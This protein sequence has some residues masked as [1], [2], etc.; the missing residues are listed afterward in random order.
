LFLISQD[1]DALSIF[2]ILDQDMVHEACK[3]F[4]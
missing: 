1:M 2:L 4:Q 3:L